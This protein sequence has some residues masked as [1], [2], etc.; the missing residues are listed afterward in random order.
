MVDPQTARLWW[1]R[2]LFIGFA[3]VL[4]FL[5]LL[6]LQTTP[7]NFAAPDFLLCLTA[8][9][10]LRRPDQVPVVS[11]AVVFLFADL[12]FQHPPGLMTALV[13][14]A[15]EFLRS[16][17][18][19]MREYPFAVEWLVFGVVAFAVMIGF[20]LT[21]QLLVL[22]PPSLWLM[23]TQYVATL[24]AYPFI[25]GALRWFLGVRHIQP[26]ERRRMRA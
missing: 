25:V 21:L 26:G 19:F 5:H 15:T 9:W 22:A 10:V 18:P 7:T 6:P 1:F 2:V 13:V 20:R 8:A 16:R 3:A 23:A 11:V 24:I 14:V 17:S 12:Y 4:V